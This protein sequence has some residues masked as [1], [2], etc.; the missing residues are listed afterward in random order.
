M[1]TSRKTPAIGLVVPRRSGLLI[2]TGVIC[3]IELVFYP[4][5]IFFSLE[6]GLS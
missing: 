4:D 6:Q 2:N 3:V 5:N 1:K